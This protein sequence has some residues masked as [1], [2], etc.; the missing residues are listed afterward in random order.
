MPVIFAR[1]QQIESFD[2][3]F[4]TKSYVGLLRTK[5]ASA[6]FTQYNVQATPTQADRQILSII[7][8]KVKFE[9]DDGRYPDL[10]DSEINNIKVAYR[11][12]F[13]NNLKIGIDT[14]RPDSDWK[15][16]GILYPRI[17]W[18][19]G[20]NSAV[21]LRGLGSTAGSQFSKLKRYSATLAPSVKAN[22][23]LSFAIS[24]T[25]LNTVRNDIANA[26]RQGG[27]PD[28]AGILRF[29]LVL[30]DP[31]GNVSY[32]NFFACK[33]TFE[34]ILSDLLVPSPPPPPALV[35][36]DSAISV[37]ETLFVPTL[38]AKFV[39]NE[40]EQNEENYEDFQTR[41]F[42]RVLERKI[43]K[44]IQ[45]N[46]SKAPPTTLRR[47]TPI[48][49][50]GPV[51]QPAPSDPYQ[52]LGISR[53]GGAIN[54]GGTVF[55][56]NAGARLAQAAGMEAAAIGNRLGG[57]TDIDSP[58]SNPFLRN[59]PASDDPFVNQLVAQIGDELVSGAS[60]ELSEL[61][62]ITPFSDRPF[63]Q[64]FYESVDSNSRYSG[65]IIVKERYDFSLDV[66][67][68]VQNII[69]PDVNQTYFLDTKIAYGEIYRY[70]IKSVF[71]FVNT[72]GEPSVF[73][74]QT[75]SV[76]STAKFT[77]F[78][79]TTA[80]V[81]FYDSEFSEEVEV[82][83][84]DFVRPDPP[85]TVRVFPDSVKKNIKLT[86]IQKNQ[87]KD[88]RG[89]NVYKKRKKEGEFF[90]RINPDI[91]GI[92]DNFFID[93]SVEKDIDYVYAVESVDVHDNRS[94]LS[95]QYSARITDLIDGARVE[96]RVALVRI[97][98]DEL[99]VPLSE[100]VDRPIHVHEKMTIIVH[101]L[102]MTKNSDAFAI[103]V[104]SLD[105]LEE[106]LI[107]LNFKQVRFNGQPRTQAIK[108]EFQKIA[109]TLRVAEEKRLQDITAIKQAAS[110]PT[111]SLFGAA[112]NNLLVLQR[113]LRR[114]GIL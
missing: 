110:G 46:W 45:L 1:N 103:R 61:Q 65:Y 60:A 102:F 112:Q 108:E 113:S 7:E 58:E 47:P 71:K 34:P 40:F 54:I 67:V 38:A 3:E 8:S 23:Q 57:A 79:G 93:H 91:I 51:A 2:N 37:Y 20:Q 30:K 94:L 105:T 97:E 84:I 12:Y 101:P 64:S 104:T 24:E 70:K 83:A 59:Q 98:G 66:F 75:L 32:N 22:N 77:D 18:N 90:Q 33:C 99:D 95:S 100:L 56:T 41:D 16:V 15:I 89:F 17:Y 63:D 74:D 78:I 76:K 96:R 86:W 39:Y 81:Y 31:S 55:S 62:E 106:K 9:V 5:D 69:L 72:T 27:T 88:V 114:S 50:S 49:R 35:E 111:T 82:E 80:N 29:I 10:T 68:P 44:F 109:E 11:Y 26:E 25:T 52:K 21:P 14:L 42:S 6:A 28:K 36:E 19:L 43:P 13:Q 48:P 92:R 53:P 107:K 73:Q 87:N 4:A 85:E